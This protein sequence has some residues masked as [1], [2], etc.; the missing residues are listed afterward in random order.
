M[1][2][3]QRFLT[4]SFAA[5]TVGWSDLRF[6]TAGTITVRATT[7]PSALVADST[8]VT[9][10]PPT[11][12]VTYASVS[13]AA[14]LPSTADTFAERI[15]AWNVQVS[16]AGGD[17]LA[18]TLTDLVLR[19]G[20]GDEIPDWALALG[21]AELRAGATSLATGVVGASTVT[22]S[23]FSHAIADGGSDTLTVHLHLSAVP[24]ALEGLDPGSDARGV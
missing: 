4:R 16:D 15:A 7:A 19:P 17:G 18:A 2:T 6:D 23:G 3:L 1:E 10:A 22:F 20:V 24:D 8:A 21:G 13:A 5:G 11:G 12:E 9:V 14:T